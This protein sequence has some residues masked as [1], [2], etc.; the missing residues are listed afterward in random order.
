M[1]IPKNTKPV[2]P[3]KFAYPIFMDREHFEIFCAAYGMFKW[4]N[5]EKDM[6]IDICEMDDWYIGVWYLSA[7]R[8]DADYIRCLRYLLI[9][10]YETEYVFPTEEPILRKRNVKLNSNDN[11]KENVED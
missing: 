7:Y 9:E 8:R 5:V 10:A 2:K 1:Y 6:Y 11:G 4:N 3:V